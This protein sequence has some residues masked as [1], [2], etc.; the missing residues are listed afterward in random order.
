MDK[1]A[2]AD[3]PKHVTYLLVGAGTASFAA[4]R[5]IKARDARAKILI[6]GDEERLPYMRPPLSKEMWYSDKVE[7]KVEGDVRFRQWN[8]RDRSVF[9]EHPTFYTS[10][11]DLAEK[12]KGGIAV[13][14]GRKV[15]R[16][17][18]TKRE[19]HLDNGSVIAYDKCLLATGGKPKP[20]AVLDR[21]AMLRRKV[22]LFRDINDFY[23]LEDIV[24][25]GNRIAI[26]GGG[27]LG[28]ELACAL[29]HY[30]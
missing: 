12:D 3:L 1:T 28:S 27:F 25:R 14:T 23:R 16:I 19:A 4:Y 9:F 15:V 18:A 30:K 7:P 2:V 29:A 17:D 10:H 5:A 26:V 24:K 6:V 21:N 22:S 11:A 13:V 20:L 8:G